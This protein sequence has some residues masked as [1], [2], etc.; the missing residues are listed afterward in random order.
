V[1][2]EFDLAEDLDAIVDRI[3]EAI[4]SGAHDGH[5]DSACPNPW[6]IVGHEAEGDEALEARCLI[7]D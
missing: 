4:C 6:F 7:H 3:G 5:R 1:Y 2:V